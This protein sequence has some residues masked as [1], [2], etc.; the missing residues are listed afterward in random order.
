MWPE[1]CQSAATLTFDFDAEELWI[2]EDAVNASRPVVLSMGTYGAKVAIPEII[3]IL[4]SY[5][6]P[7]TF[8][9]PGK[10]AERHREA[11]SQVLE[12]GHELAIH[13]Y[14]HRAP[15]QMSPEEE[16]EELDRTLTLLRSF[17]AQPTGY[18]PPNFEISEHTLTLL[19]GRG[20][21]YSS[22]FMD[23][24]RPYRHYGRE[25]IELP[26]Q[27]IL[28]DAPHFWFDPS[29]WVKK[30]STN[31]EVWEIW[32]AE[33]DAIHTMGG[34]SVITMHPQI[35]GRPGRLGLLRCLVEY[36]QSI[37][38]LWLTT[39]ENIATQFASSAH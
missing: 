30:I 4:R 5:G 39:C 36:L 20:L 9:V 12:S 32:K 31:K 18:R 25:L 26:L 33:I 7:A 22:T 19:E 6:T 1:G 35:I 16:A 38:G 23:D 10:V 37:P 3:R 29:T 28:D 34:L 13:G 2:G 8:F 11:V 15:N 21:L 24:I 14:T 17:G 27:W